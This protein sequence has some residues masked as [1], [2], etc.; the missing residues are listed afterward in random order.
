M[1]QNG[2]ALL[3][4]VEQQVHDGEIGGKGAELL[5]VPGVNIFVVFQKNAMIL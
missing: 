5:R 3:S 1:G 2:Q 4:V